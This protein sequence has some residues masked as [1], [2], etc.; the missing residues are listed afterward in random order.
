[1]RGDEIGFVEIEI[2]DLSNSF[3]L[4]PVSPLMAIFTL[5][6]FGNGFLFEQTRLITIELLRN[7]LNN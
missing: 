2:L 5:S 6:I 4:R 3:S 1:M 7:S